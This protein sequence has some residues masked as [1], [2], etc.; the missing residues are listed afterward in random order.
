M[1]T[2]DAFPGRDDLDAT[3]ARLDERSAQLAQRAKRLTNKARRKSARD[4]LR[5]AWFAVESLRAAD[6]ASQ[7]ARL[8]MRR[9]RDMELA[10]AE[11]LGIDPHSALTPPVQAPPPVSAVEEAWRNHRDPM[12]L[13]WPIRYDLERIE[14]LGGPGRLADEM[15]GKLDDAAAEIEARARKAA[16]LSPLETRELEPAV[17]MDVMELAKAPTKKKPRL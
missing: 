3:A 2:G 6:P 17:D 12:R 9:G 13:D 1:A 11:A 8:A 7:P 16:G 14:R 10:L 4:L 15:A 5:Q